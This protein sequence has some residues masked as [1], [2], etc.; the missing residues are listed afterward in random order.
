LGDHSNAS[1]ER[2]LNSLSPRRREPKSSPTSGISLR[3]QAASRTR[4][5]QGSASEFPKDFVPYPRRPDVRCSMIT[6][7]PEGACCCGKDSQELEN[8]N[9]AKTGLIISA[10]HCYLA[11]NDESKSSNTWRV[12]SR[13]ILPDIR[14]RE[15]CNVM[16]E[17]FVYLERRSITQQDY[18][19]VLTSAERA[20]SPN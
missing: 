2:A 7:G 4:I 8:T 15:R 5:L 16:R 14:N 3:R 6:S 13:P 20:P 9:V 10:A 17:S 1:T 12:L 18:G 19:K 11:L